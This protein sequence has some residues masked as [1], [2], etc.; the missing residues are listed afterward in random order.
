MID[1]QNNQ[2][3]FIGELIND[4]SKRKCL[5]Y[6]INEK[7]IYDQHLLAIVK[8]LKEEEFSLITLK[9]TYGKT[10][11]LKA[12]DLS[13]KAAKYKYNRMQMSKKEKVT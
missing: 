8:S 1:V 7:F 6:L 2:N 12:I 11:L 5:S 4:E 9:K 10:I 13:Q 3:L